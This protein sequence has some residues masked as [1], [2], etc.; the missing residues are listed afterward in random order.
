MNPDVKGKHFCASLQDFIEGDHVKDY[1][2]VIFSGLSDELASYASKKM[3]FLDIPCI[4][5]KIVGFFMHVRL[6]KQL[7]FVESSKTT[8]QK[9]YLRITDP[10]PELSAYAQQL[11]VY[12]LTDR[13]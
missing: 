3:W 5:I 8:S 9:Y 4:F 13:I 7:H 11:S 10:F 12:D 6:Q 2:L 1:N